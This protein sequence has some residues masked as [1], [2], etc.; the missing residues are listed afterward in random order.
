MANPSGHVMLD[1]EAARTAEERYVALE[2]ELQAM[3]AR[4]EELA[5]RLRE[6]EEVVVAER[7]WADR[8]AQS[9]NAQVCEPHG[10][11]ISGVM[12]TRCAN[13][14]HADRSKGWKT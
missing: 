7:L 6:Q 14:R 12:R 9:T 1:E 10:G 5:S 2:A 4:N 13:G 11:A 3:R 8:R